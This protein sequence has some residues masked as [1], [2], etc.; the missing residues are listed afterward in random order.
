[1]IANRTL[2]SLP[3]EGDVAEQLDESLRTA[4]GAAYAITREVGA[5]GMARV[6]SAHDHRHDR[7]VAVKVLRPELTESLGRERFARE[8]H[9]A[10]RLT[11]PNV[12]PLYDSGEAGGYL[13]FVM[14]VLPASES[15]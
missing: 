3:L 13:F 5:G 11:H 9:L 2:S 15:R 4:L 12:L 8:I 7:Q 6:Y 14:L 10:A 1:L